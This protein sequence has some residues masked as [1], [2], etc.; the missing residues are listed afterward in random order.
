MQWIRGRFEPGVGDE[1]RLQFHNSPVRPLVEPNKTES[2]VIGEHGPAREEKGYA[3]ATFV[4]VKEAFGCVVQ[5]VEAVLVASGFDDTGNIE[6]LTAR[7]SFARPRFIVLQRDIEYAAFV[8]LLDL[9]YP[10]LYRT[11]ADHYRWLSA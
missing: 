4:G 3:G 2:W 5:V 9:L 6:E 10:T 8:P 1:A 7:S 11:L